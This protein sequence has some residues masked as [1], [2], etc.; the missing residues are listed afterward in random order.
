MIY[1]V[2]TLCPCPHCQHMK[3]ISCVMAMAARYWPWVIPVLQI[4]C[5][6]RPQLSQEIACW[7]RPTSLRQK[8]QGCCTGLP[9][10]MLRHELITW[11]TTCSLKTYDNPSGTTEAVIIDIVYHGDTMALLASLKLVVNYPVIKYISFSNGTTVIPPTN[12]NLAVNF[13]VKLS[14]DKNSSI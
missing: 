8:A 4:R 3:G 7:R 1:Y 12:F 2:F 14:C 11:I 13:S 9:F 6:H 10:S 5:C